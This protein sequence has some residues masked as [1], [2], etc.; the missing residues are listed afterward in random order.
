MF[1]SANLEKLEVLPKTLISVINTE[2]LVL[3]QVQCN[4]FS[5]YLVFVAN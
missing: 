1:K 5:L 3:G 4:L 2:S